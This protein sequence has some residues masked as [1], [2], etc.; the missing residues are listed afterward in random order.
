MGLNP[1]GKFLVVRE[2]FPPQCFA[3]V[4]NTLLMFSL[5]VIFLGRDT[6]HTKKNRCSS[7]SDER[8]QVERREETKT[9]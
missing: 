4:K 6:T 9:Q 2:T 7:I 3:L 5:R 1:L 8:R